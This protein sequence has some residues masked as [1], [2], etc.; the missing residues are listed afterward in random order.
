M[1]KVLQQKFYFL[2]FVN[3]PN[4]IEIDSRGEKL[5]IYDILNFIHVKYRIYKFNI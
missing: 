2:L 3:I 5:Q 1:K 4:F